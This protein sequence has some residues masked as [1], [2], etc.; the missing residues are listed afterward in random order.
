MDIIKLNL[1]RNCLKYICK[2]Y[3]IN[4][5]FLPYYTC[6]VV[7]NAVREENCE[8]NFYHIGRDFLPTEEFTKDSFI[9]YTNY[10]GI[11][12]DNCKLLAKKYPNLIIDNSQGF[13]AEPLGLASFNSLRKFFNVQNGAYL[14]TSK[15]LEQEFKTDEIELTPISMQKNY[16]KFL[17]NELFLDSQKDIKIISPK[18]EQEMENIDLEKEKRKRIELFKQYA[19]VF[20]EYNNIPTTLKDGKIPYCYPFSPN[21]EKIKQKL[22]AKNLTLLQ[23]W[24]NFPKS[25]IESEILN[26]TI[27]FPLDDAE[28]VE[29][30]IS[31]QLS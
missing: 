17:K 1:A 8:V 6:P 10:F 11:N 3:R 29:K 16:E 4:K 22:L 28:Y 25:F 24:K 14:F 26:D 9:L 15:I 21:N 20:D 18:V 5:I 13:F 2:T 23:L 12:S 7:W 19:Q 27:A 31:S 30:I